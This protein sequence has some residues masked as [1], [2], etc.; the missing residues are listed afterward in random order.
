MRYSPE[1]NLR[2]ISFSFKIIS[3]KTYAFGRDN[4]FYRVVAMPTPW[5]AGRETFYSHPATFERA[6]FF[7]GFYTIGRAG[8]GVTALN[9]EKRGN[10]GLVEAYEP[11]E[12]YGKY[13]THLRALKWIAGGLCL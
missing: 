11:D 6:V 1:A 10:K 13:L 4:L 12:Q 9:P 7:D 3:L 2:I 5:M 8:R